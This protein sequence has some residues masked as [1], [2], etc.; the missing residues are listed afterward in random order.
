MEAFLFTGWWGERF[1]R[2]ERLQAPQHYVDTMLKPADPA[3]AEAEALAKFRR[4]AEDWGL[5]V[6]GGAE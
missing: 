4:M 3:L 6:E 1:A 5:Q 2:E